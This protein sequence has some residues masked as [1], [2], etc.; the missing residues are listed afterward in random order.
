VLPKKFGRTTHAGNVARHAI[1]TGLAF[2]KV[3]TTGR[4]R[5]VG[6]DE[7]LQRG[8]TPSWRLVSTGEI[9]PHLYARVMKKRRKPERETS[10][11]CVGMYG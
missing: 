4:R 9:P 6:V 10:I 2:D 11:V 1:D 8:C 5:V 3:Q 7:A